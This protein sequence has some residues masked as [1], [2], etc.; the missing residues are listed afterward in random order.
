ME[1][2]VDEVKRIHKELLKYD[3]RLRQYER[4]I[5]VIRMLGLKVE[6]SQIGAY[7]FKIKTGVRWYIGKSDFERIFIFTNQEDKCDWWI[8]TTVE[9]IG[10]EPTEAVLRVVSK[11]LKKD[12]LYCDRYSGHLYLD[13]GGGIWLKV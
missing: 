8:P 10:E 13:L 9:E 6:D 7:G 2:I 3:R 12:K 11:R 4:A 5:E 1:N